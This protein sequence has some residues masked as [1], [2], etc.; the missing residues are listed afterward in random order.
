[1]SG[2]PTPNP[3]GSCYGHFARVR[4]LS[5]L[6]AGAVTVGA[7]FALAQL[8]PTREL[9]LK[10]RKPGEGPSPEQRAKSRFSVIF[11]AEGGGR[12]VM[13]E[14]SGGDPGYGETSKMIAESA[15][16]LARDRDALPR[17]YGVLTP[18]VAMGDVLLERLQRAGIAFKVLRAE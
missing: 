1:M 17:R 8:T 16:A 18:A 3:S 6:V 2:H 11:L 5:T 9:L 12:R 14:V 4:S 13:T 15:L 10:M 7:I